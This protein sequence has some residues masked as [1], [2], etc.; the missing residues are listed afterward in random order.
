MICEYNPLHLGHSKQLA[1][2]RRLAG[3]EGAVVCLMS[4]NY[5]QRGEPA[6]FSKN[7]RAEAAIRC[8]AD[9]VLE[10]PIPYAL[11]SAEGFAAGGVE[12]LTRLGVGQL[13]FG[14][15]TGAADALVSTAE[16]LLSAEFPRKL[17]IYLQEGLSFPAARQ[18]ALED[19]GGSGKVV[20]RPNDILAVEYCK[21]I[22]RT[23]S[24]MKIHPIRRPGD[25]HGGAFDPE[26]PSAAALRQREDWLDYVPAGA[27]A[28]FRGARRHTLAAGERVI[29]ARL[30]TME[31]EAFAALPFGSEGLWRKFMANCRTQTGVEAI[32]EATKSKR[33]TRTRLN[34]MLLCAVLGISREDMDRSV[35]YVRVLGLSRRGGTLVRRAR[36][37]GKLNLVNAGQKQEGPY[38]DLERRAGEYYALFAQD[39]PELP[40]PEERSRVFCLREECNETE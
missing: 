29:L 38:W 40:G 11:S 26:N 13:C 18:R 9:L 3:P 22:L 21:A 34:R 14:S 32:L 2:M 1:E 27:R 4:G 39:A 20:Q 8:G 19:L 10:L 12:I 33:Y 37:Q 36:K 16:L 15:E 17:G 35:P 25:Y 30:R 7:C 5:V 28:A 31:E 24:T 6:L 23:G